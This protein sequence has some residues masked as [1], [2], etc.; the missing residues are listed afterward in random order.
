MGLLELQHL[1][2]PRFSTVFGMLVFLTNLSLLEFL[3]RYLVFFPLFLVIGGFGWVWMGNLHK[4]IQLT[5]KC[6]KGPFLDLHLSYYALVTFLMILSVILLSLLIILLSSCGNNQSWL[7]ELKLIYKTLDQGRKW[8]VDF[9]AGKS[10]LVSFDWSNNTV[11]IDVK[12]DG[13]VLEEKLPLKMLGLTF[14]SKL[15]WSSYIISINE[16]ASQKIRSLICSMKFPSPEGAL[17]CHK[18]TI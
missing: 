13:S 5:L 8:L 3:V 1:I 16:A 15:D 2:Y 6:L 10:Q 7:L 18:C 11:A 14:S 12:M 17:Y 4:N 9:S